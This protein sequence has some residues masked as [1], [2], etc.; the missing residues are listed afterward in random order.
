MNPPSGLNTSAAPFRPALHRFGQ[1]WH[2]RPSRSA[3]SDGPW[4]FR[5]GREI[6]R[7]TWARECFEEGEPD[8][9]GCLDGFG[10]FSFFQRG[11]SPGR[12]LHIKAP[13]PY[14]GL[15]WEGT[16]GLVVSHVIFPA[17]MPPQ[18]PLSPRWRRAW[19][20]LGW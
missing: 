2:K 18:H 19:P 5:P 6:R 20:L 16:F 1:D 12:S 9:I 3:N 15:G 13:H 17:Q 7:S 10:L 11:S 8:C 4:A 14:L